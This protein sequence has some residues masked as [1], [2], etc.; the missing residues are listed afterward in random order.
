MVSG[1]TLHPYSAGETDIHSD[2]FK[3]NVAA[4]LAGAVRLLLVV[5]VA[6][7]RDTMGGELAS[8]ASDSERAKTGAARRRG[9]RWWLHPR[10]QRKGSRAAGVTEGAHTSEW[11]K[12]EHV[13]TT[14]ETRFHHTMRTITGA[15]SR[16]QWHGMSVVAFSSAMWLLITGLVLCIQFTAAD[17]DPPHDDFLV[18]PDDEMPALR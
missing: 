8:L 6:K 16:G 15:A 12:V 9:L 7:G 13:E 4:R 11:R 2:H 10:K 14:A 17:F 1:E 18:A 3:T 5:G